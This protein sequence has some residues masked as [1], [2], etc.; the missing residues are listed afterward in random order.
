MTETIRVLVVDDYP[1]VRQGLQALISAKPGITVIGEAADGVEAVR[2][3]RSLQPDVILMDLLMPRKDGVEATDEILREDPHARILVLT[4]FF[5]DD[6]I[7][8]AIEAGALGYVLKD[9]SSEEL[10]QAI[11]DVHRGEPSLSPGVVGGLMREVRRGPEP[12]GVEE[13]LTER[14]T[15]VLRLVARGLSNADIAEALSVSLWTVRS[16]VSSILDKLR[17]ANRTQ[18]ALYALRE[19]I[20]RLDS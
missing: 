8:S 4:S 3:A 9:S 7:F 5:A 10:V 19:G 6:R 13:P 12:R 11:H 18:A 2:K 16:R 14:E 1:V 17:V 15:E 20:A